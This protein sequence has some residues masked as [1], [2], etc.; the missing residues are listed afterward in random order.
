MLLSETLLLQLSLLSTRR[1]RVLQLLLWTQHHLH[2]QSPRCQ[3]QVKLH[4]RRLP[5]RR[6]QVDNGASWTRAP[7]KQLCRWL[8]TMLADMVVQTV[9]R[10]SRA[11]LAMILTPCK[12]MPPTPST[13]TT[14]RILFPLAVFLEERHNSPQL[15]QVRYFPDTL[16]FSGKLGSIIYFL[17][18]FLLKK[19][20]KTTLKFWVIS[21]GSNLI[22]NPTKALKWADLTGT[23]LSTKKISWPL[24]SWYA[25][26]INFGQLQ[27]AWLIC[28][29]LSFCFIYGRPW[30]LSLCIFW[31]IFKTYSF[32]SLI[33]IY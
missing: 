21:T 13:I 19:I 17:N 28:I 11:R 32:L 1:L 27:C 10:Y 31:V 12:I 8:S 30:K 18:L 24:K 4:L 23:I 14:R 7:L 2:H 9:H 26:K 5:R 6:H 3:S 20:V 33:A 16:S 29:D 15:T 25:Q 22:H